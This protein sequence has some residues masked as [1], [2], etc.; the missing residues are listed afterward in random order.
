MI[1]KLK[2][3]KQELLAI[4]ESVKD[5][6]I[7][8]AFN[9]LRTPQNNARHLEEDLFDF[10]TTCATSTIFIKDGKLKLSDS[11]EFWIENEKNELQMFFEYL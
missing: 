8:D 3:T 7:E 9:K 6:S 1:K 10:D 5:L 4:Y 11:F 2:E